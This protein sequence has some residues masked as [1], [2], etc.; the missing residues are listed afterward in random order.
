[1]RLVGIVLLWL[2]FAPWLSLAGVALLGLSL[3]PMFPS[4][5]SLTPA[6]M[7]PA[8]AANTVGFQI[9]AAMLGGAALVSGFGVIAEQF[10]VDTLGPY[11][12]IVAIL[13]TIV[14]EI[15]ERQTPGSRVRQDGEAEPA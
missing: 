10:G 4:L 2:N 15:L 12:L 1:M 8:H 11:L 9:A 13:L 5:I 6:R 14:F 3:A 7:G